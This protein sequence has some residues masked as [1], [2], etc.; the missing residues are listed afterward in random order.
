MHSFRNDYSEGAH[1]VV[2]DALIRTNLEQ[3]DGYTS[4]PHCDNARA[5][6]RQAVA[7]AV[8]AEGGCTDGIDQLQV[9]FVAGG[10][11]ANLLV[12]A[13]AL[14]PHQCVIAAPDGH[15][16][17]HE[18]GAIEA[19]GHKVVVTDDVDGIL[20]VKGVE[21]AMKFH[22]MGEWCHMV[23][24]HILYFSFATESGM[25]HS[26][27]QL[28]EL[29]QYADEHGLLIYIDGARL[30][31]GLV[32]DGTDATLN[33]IYQ[34][35]DA[36]TFGG[37]KNGAM[38]GEAVVIKNPEIG[39]CFQFMMKQRGGL[40]AKGRL[41]GVQFE[42]LFGT[43]GAEAGV[44]EAQGDEILYFSLARHSVGLA[45]QVRE[46]LAKHGF[47]NFTSA[48]RTNQ[49]FIQVPNAVADQLVEMFGCEIF[50]WPND[51]DAEIRFVCSWATEQEH[52]ADLDAALAEMVS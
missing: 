50:G 12:I 44:A 25:V 13:S 18:T 26:A 4:D 2:L 40:T 22:F 3:T 1:P 23:S 46:I 36:F 47:D 35:A 28:R 30:G 17:V 42:A 10:T 34:C 27:Q 48:S 33:D 49:Q 11:M 37:T 32:C 38:F 39:S 5:L 20:T 21:A 29:R 41:L 19:T 6:I 15:I 9:E 24:P 14:R 51:E 8:E 45:L 43:T 52:L 16:N 31:C 7:K